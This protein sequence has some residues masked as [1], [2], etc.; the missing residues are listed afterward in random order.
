MGATCSVRYLAGNRHRTGGREVDLRRGIAA[1]NLLCVLVDACKEPWWQAILDTNI[2]ELVTWGEVLNGL[3]TR[4]S[5]SRQTLG[6]GF[7]HHGF[8][9]G[10]DAPC[11]IASP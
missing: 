5:L 2:I 3:K 10:F 6:P 7:Y 4:R 11:A 8:V 1:P 9:D